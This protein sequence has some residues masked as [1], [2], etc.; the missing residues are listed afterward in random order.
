MPFSTTSYFFE[1]V[2]VLIKTQSLINHCILGGIN[3]GVEYVLVEI[4]LGD[5]HVLEL[6]GYNLN[7]RVH[8]YDWNVGDE[9]T[10]ERHSNGLDGPTE[11]D[12]DVDAFFLELLDHNVF[13]LSIFLPDENRTKVVLF[14]EWI[15][16][17]RCLFGRIE[18]LNHLYMSGYRQRS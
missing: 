8:V 18:Y 17:R 10:Q 16:I 5:Y 14:L 4:Q 2:S 1:F 15:S 9:V 11:I 13:Y 3:N 12:L 7:A 6:F